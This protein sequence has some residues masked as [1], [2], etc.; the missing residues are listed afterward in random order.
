M[1]ASPD[2]QN[3]LV[4]HT[5]ASVRVT[6]HDTDRMG[7]VYHSQYLVWFE[8]GRTELLRSLGTSYKTWEDDHGVY[9]PVSSADIK[10]LVPAR[11]DDLIIIKTDM[12]RLTRASV[13]FQYQ[14]HLAEGSQLLATGQ[15]THA[16]VSAEG[17][18][19]RIANELLP[20]L[21]Q[22]IN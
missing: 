18:I 7:Y 5:T 12:V 22:R 11:Y 3:L 19:L 9:L 8:I 20:Q 13:T 17:K 16:F 2:Q 10:Y 1:T 21:F 4:S 14:V 6:Y 15:T